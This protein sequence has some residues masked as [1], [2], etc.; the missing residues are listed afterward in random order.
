LNICSYN[1]KGLFNKINYPHFFEF[2]NNQDVFICLETHIYETNKQNQVKHYF[3]NFNLHW[4]L[5]EKIAVRGRGISGFLVGWK[6]DLVKRFNI[7][8]EV[9][10]EEG[11]ITLNI[12]K[13]REVIKIIPLYIRSQ[14][15]DRNIS[16]LRSNLSNQGFRKV[17]V[18]GDM[19]VRIGEIQQELLEEVQHGSKVLN[20][21]KS[22][23]KEINQKGRVFVEF[24]NDYNLRILNGAFFGD[25]EGCFTYCSSCGNSVNDIATATS[26]LL[27]RIESF[28]VIN[29][30]W[31]DH[32]P[33]Q[34]S[35]RM[36]G[37]TED[38]QEMHLLPKLVWKDNQR[39]QY[40]A[41]LNH[42]LAIRDHPTKVEDLCNIIKMAAPKTPCFKKKNLWKEKWFDKDCE[43]AR[44]LSFKKLTEWRKQ[45]T[46]GK[47]QEYVQS[48]VS[49]SRLLKVKKE[50]YIQELRRKLNTVQNSKEWW[51]L[52]KDY[53]T[54]RFTVGKSL[55]A[56]DFKVYFEKLLNPNET[57][58][59]YHYA[60]PLNHS[61]ILDRD[62]SAEEVIAALNTLKIG[63]AA[64]EDRI[65]YEFFKFAS[66]NFHSAL[67]IA[68]TS[69]LNSTNLDALFFKNI[70][71]PIF[72]KGNPDTPDNYRGI[73]FM[74]CAAKVLMAVLNKRL[75]SWV[76]ENKILNE[77]QAGFRP[78]YST[79]DNIYNLSSMIHLKFEEKKKV[80]AFFV[81][82]KAAFDRVS[83]GALMYKLSCIGVSTKYI[84]LLIKLY[85]GTMS[86]VWNGDELSDYF[87]TYS[88]VKQGC[89]LSPLLFALFL[90]DLHD[91]LQGGLYIDDVNIRVLLYADDIVIVA[92][93]PKSLQTMIMNLEKY[94]NN[95]NMSVNMNKSKIM[96]FRKGGRIRSDE[97]WTFNGTQVEI[98]KSY[99][100][101]GVIFTPKMSFAQHILERT[102]KAKASVYGVWENLLL[103]DNVDIKTKIAIFKAVSRSIQCYGS[104]VFGYGYGDQINQLQVFFLKLALRLPQFTPTYAV[105]LESQ[106]TPS[107][108]YCLRLH[109]EY[110]HK[111]LFQY[112]ADRLPHI[113]SK[114]V[115]EKQVFWFEHWCNMESLTYVQW[116]S[117]SLN[118]QRWNFCIKAAVQNYSVSDFNKRVSQKNSSIRRFYRKLKHNVDYINAANL[119]TADVRF[120]LRARCD[121]LGLNGNRLNAGA[122]TRCSLCN[123]NADENL[124]HFVGRCPI[125]REFRMQVL[126]KSIL[127]E[128]EVTA[129]LNGEMH[130]WSTVA[131]FI[132]TAANHRSDLIQEFNF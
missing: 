65:P 126:G 42:Y 110:I 116:R 69:I 44:K 131:N 101:L 58:R 105:Y 26:A 38:Y 15:F 45:R 115:V 24:C 22:Q 47:R 31:S 90:N 75:M 97:H 13:N 40:C 28:K 103:D 37:T 41:K 63:K 87:E 119:K 33:I 92:D 78:K 107:S 59:S 127:D 96:V 3:P 80:Y 128:S 73:T 102:K 39:M 35:L 17:I 118:K 2:L 81:D 27:Q 123:L 12:K 64:G 48:N 77:Y 91:E 18:M 99:V 68:F 60:A 20:T 14:E 30:T 54:R 51:S 67:A 94:C 53:S 122:E 29:A 88:G 83:R 112:G 10:E 19:N 82:F 120:I 72:K 125:L 106:E 5:A 9:S 98:V 109:M 55:L 108:T 124:L 74:N 129:L 52:A 61:E 111:T 36:E 4:K 71:F 89:L 62:I 66:S 46:A 117:V 104:Q 130:P 43:N 86:A 8:V 56:E 23:D 121:L 49:Y 34:I 21:R 57:L 6:R 25:E 16:N 79:I 50:S 1:I 32:F 70:I 95:W 100:Y 132:K 7:N 85:T 11:C 84:N 93:E 114:K 113:L 76:I